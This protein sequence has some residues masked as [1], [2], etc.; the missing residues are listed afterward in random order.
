MVPAGTTTRMGHL[1]AVTPTVPATIVPLL[2]TTAMDPTARATTIRMCHPPTIAMDLAIT[3]LR[4][5]TVRTTARATTTRMGH[6]TMITLTVPTRITIVPMPATTAMDP[7]TKAPRIPTVRTILRVTTIH[8]GRPAMITPTVPTRT[9]IVPIPATTAMDPPTKVPR[10]PTVR[11]ILRATT[12]RMG[13]RM[14][15]HLETTR[16]A[17]RTPVTTTHTGPAAIN[18][19]RIR[20]VPATTNRPTTKRLPILMA[21]ETTNQLPHPVIRMKMSTTRV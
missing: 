9:T 10:I 19:L 8:M 16:M 2:T 6:P 20:M 5:L 12:T 13:L 15:A 18:H 4:T 7:P 11:T 17:P 1:V 14:T 21:L 3:V